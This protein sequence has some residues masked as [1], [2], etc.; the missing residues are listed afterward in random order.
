MPVTTPVPITTTGGP[1]AAVDTDLLVAPW[2]EDDPAGA[3]PGLDA[4]TGGEIARAIASKEFAAQPFDLFLAPVANADWRA[5]R[6]AL[7]GGGKSR[8]FGPEIAR[9]LAAA[10]GLAARQR[11]IGR[12]AFVLRTDTSSA[13]EVTALAQ[14]VAEGLSLAEFNVGSHKTDEP[15]LGNTPVW[16]ITLTSEADGGD[17]AR[18]GAGRVQQPGPRARQ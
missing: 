1:L 9:K 10:A 11:R 2:F 18:T 3:V 16:T 7:M 5:R 8:E 4:A 15:A 6:V 17:C 14:A 12:V 13:V